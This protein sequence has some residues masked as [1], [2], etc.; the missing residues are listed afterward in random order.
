[1]YIDLKNVIEE[2]A[3][4][5]KYAT[6]VDD[7][8]FV[9]RDIIVGVADV[10]G[11]YMRSGDKIYVEALISAPISFSCD[12]CLLKCSKTLK[13]SLNEVFGKDGDYVYE[14]NII[15][16]DKAVRDAIILNMPEQLLCKDECEGLCQ[17]CGC[18]KNTHECDC[19]QDDDNNPFAILK[20]IT[21]GAKNG[22]TK[23]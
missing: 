2:Q 21:G 23:K 11:T 12:K 20:S 18:D 1:M 6:K 7:G 22:S 9:D 17:K 8:L 13:I 10:S 14:N 5:L 4:P 16:L 15:E 19:Q 3:Y